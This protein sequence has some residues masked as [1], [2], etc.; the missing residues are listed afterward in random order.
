MWRA[1]AAPPDLLIRWI[2]A[3]VLLASAELFFDINIFLKGNILSSRLAE[4]VILC[5]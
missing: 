1:E 2:L 4:N 3:A 5:G